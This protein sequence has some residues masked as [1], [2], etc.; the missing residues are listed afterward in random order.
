MV[1]T[2]RIQPLAGTM[3]AH[4]GSFAIPF[5]TAVSQ[6]IVNVTVFFGVVVLFFPELLVPLVVL[7]SV[8]GISTLPS[9][10][11]FFGMGIVDC[12]V[13]SDSSGISEGLVRS[14]FVFLSEVT[15]Y[16]S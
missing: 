9:V 4:F 16:R 13:S 8:T 2:G 1:I 14:V 5:A 7:S 6:R 11:S 3:P 12:W 10:L 15:P